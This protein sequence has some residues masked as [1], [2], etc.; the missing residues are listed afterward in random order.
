MTVHDT[1]TGKYLDL[2][3]KPICGLPSG[4][5][6]R[7]QCEVREQRQE[8]EPHGMGQQPAGVDKACQVDGLITTSA[9]K[10]G[11]VV[12][13]DAVS[14]V[15]AACSACGA[16]STQ[17]TA[18]EVSVVA[19]TAGTPVLEKDIE[20]QVLA[21]M[22][23]VAM[24]NN[25]ATAWASA[26]SAARQLCHAALISLCEQVNGVLGVEGGGLQSFVVPL[27]TGAESSNGKASSNAVVPW[28]LDEVKTEA[29]TALD[30]LRDDLD[31]AVEGI[32]LAAEQTARTA[33]PPLTVTTVSSQT[34]S[35][36]PIV[37]G[38]TESRTTIGSQTGEGPIK[39]EM[40]ETRRRDV[41]VQ[42][43]RLGG[44]TRKNISGASGAS[45]APAWEGDINE[46][47]FD[48]EN[49]N[50]G[51]ERRRKL[52]HGGQM[53][54]LKRKT[55]ALSEALQRAEAEK[56]NLEQTLAR[57]YEREKV[58]AGGISF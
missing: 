8:E 22:A 46:R 20:A 49:V 55:E 33:P 39:E 16:D 51:R 43:G 25:R 15:C 56:G 26:F 53:E 31:S 57:R 14:R 2:T 23:S 3:T 18:N 42:T 30:S 28:V 27:L 36:P 58:S 38:T 34:A 35:E 21:A 44:R 48:G 10:E 54:E 7:L 45:E 9:E 13:S 41:G 4:S 47:C 12:Q 32:R 19:S 50:S 1:P 29:A 37:V 11:L 5:C 6:G 52:E 24:A 40:R 17:S